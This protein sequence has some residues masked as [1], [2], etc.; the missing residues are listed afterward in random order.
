MARI[1]VC[2][3]GHKKAEQLEFYHKEVEPDLTKGG[4]EVHCT[5]QTEVLDQVV[6]LHPD[7]LILIALGR[8]S[9]S[10]NIVRHLRSTR[11]KG[12]PHIL[13]VIA[14]GPEDSPDNPAY[15]TLLAYQ[16]LYD[17]YWPGWGFAEWLEDFQTLG[18]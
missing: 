17:S 3:D 2:L 11:E 18:F 12:D 8:Q 15:Y 16:P 9:P 4:Y 14:F 13:M 6:N 1:L 10:W 7:F 5:T